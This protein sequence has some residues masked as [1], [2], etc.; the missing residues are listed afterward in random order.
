[1]IFSDEEGEEKGLGESKTRVAAE[2]SDE[3]H[4]DQRAG[5]S[6]HNRPMP[7]A[8]FHFANTRLDQFPTSQKLEEPIYDP[9][10]WFGGEK[11]ADIMFNEQGKKRGKRIPSFEA[12]PPSFEARPP[13]L[14]LPRSPDSALR[15]HKRLA[16]RRLEYS[17]DDWWSARK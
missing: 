2:A 5:L 13:S 4:C 10:R 3:R 12:R 11:K 6:I 8:P 14:R 15:P 7:H 16:S 1:M 9:S 17:N